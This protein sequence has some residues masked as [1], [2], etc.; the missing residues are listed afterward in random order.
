LNM[1]T[2]NDKSPTFNIF[3]REYYELFDIFLVSSDL[4][5]K[6]SDFRVLSKHD[7]TSDHF[8]IEACISI[9]HIMTSDLI[10]RRLNF[11]KANWSY[12]QEILSVPILNPDSVDDYN[13]II[14]KKI[15]SA[16][17]KSIPLQS[18]KIYKLPYRMKL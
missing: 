14:S 15:I 17:H 6:I 18:G 9:E 11:K 13:N 7:M 3:N 12:F 1:S 2:I 16:A 8:P 4:S 5:D 10:S